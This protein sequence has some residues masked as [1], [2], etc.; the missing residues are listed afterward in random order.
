MKYVNVNRY[1]LFVDMNKKKLQ[2]ISRLLSIFKSLNGDDFD[3]VCLN[4]N[5]ESIQIFLEVV[6]NLISNE[7]LFERVEN[8]YCLKVYVML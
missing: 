1:L 6:F 4:A 5:N 7:S 8:I 2:T 3:F